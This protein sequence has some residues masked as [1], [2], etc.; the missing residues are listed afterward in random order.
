MNVVY[1][2]PPPPPRILHNHCFQL[3]LGITVIPR[4]IQDNGCA[5]FVGEKKVHYGIC[6]SCLR[7]HGNSDVFKTQITTSFHLYINGKSLKLKRS[8]PN[9]IRLAIFIS[10]CS[11]FQLTFCPKTMAQRVFCSHL[12]FVNSVTLDIKL[13]GMIFVR[14]VE[15]F[16]VGIIPY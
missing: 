8:P 3:L 16:F 11:C 14:Q 7:S 9:K 4:E 15:P 13:L 10:T 6:E 5:I 12:Y 1:P 2:P